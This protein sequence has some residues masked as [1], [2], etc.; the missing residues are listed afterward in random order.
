[1]K[2]VTLAIRGGGVK[3]PT[4]GVLQAFEENNII[5]LTVSG[6]SMGAVIA[7]L[8]AVGMKA[9]KID[10]LFK[11]YVIAYSSTHNSKII[12]DTVNAECG[13]LTFR[14]VPKT[15]YIVANQGGLIN[16]K[17][18]IFSQQTTPDITVG[19]ACRASCSFPLI[20]GRYT[21]NIDGNKMKFYDG[22]MC[23][24][25]FLPKHANSVTVLSTFQKANVNTKSRYKNAWLLP[26]QNADFVIKP[27]IGKMG[28]RGTPDDVELSK[29]LGYYQ[30]QKH[31]DDLLKILE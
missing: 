19:Q 13:N 2:N 12:E 14:H 23:M 11:K 8:V 25:P 6:S 4:I 10:Q 20:Y 30:A 21:L 7:T 17:A 3:T 24:N 15:L 5:P 31:M 26:E 29:I 16:T 9:S 18:F 28:S 1:M 27:Y 22:G